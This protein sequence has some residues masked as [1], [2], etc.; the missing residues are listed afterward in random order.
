M[1]ACGSPVPQVYSGAQLLGKEDGHLHQVD[2]AMT[3]WSSVP[4]V[5]LRHLAPR[6]LSVGPPAPGLQSL[7]AVASTWLGTAPWW[8]SP[9][10]KVPA[11]FKQP[12]D[13]LPGATRTVLVTAR[14]DEDGNALQDNFIGAVVD[15]APTDP[16]LAVK[17]EEELVGASC[18]CQMSDRG[19]L[20]W[21][22]NASRT[23]RT[24]S[25][26]STSCPRQGRSPRR[27]RR[28]RE[29]R[30]AREPA[31]ERHEDATAPAHEVRRQRQAGAAQPERRACCSVL[32]AL[33]RG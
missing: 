6:S 33:P 18:V 25:T 12:V 29:R 11:R 4:G 26:T 28:G 16:L 8:W 10:K 23:T 31:T 19:F 21:I 2:D 5:A 3:R 7:P 15:L 20:E 9:T 14:H 17:G 30:C 13:A 1:A 27:R 32:I 24:T 22:S